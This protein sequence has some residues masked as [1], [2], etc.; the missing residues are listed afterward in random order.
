MGSINQPDV[1]TLQWWTTREVG[2]RYGYDDSTVRRW[3]ES[4][5]IKAVKMPSGTWRIHSSVVDSLGA[6][7]LPPQERVGRHAP[8]E[9]QDAPDNFDDSPKSK[10]RVRT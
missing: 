8:A 3:C 2:N 9:F 1:S 7:G 6:A 10:A 5:K 4:G